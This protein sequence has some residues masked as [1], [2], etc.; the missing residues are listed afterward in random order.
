MFLKLKLLQN[1]KKNQ[2]KLSIYKKEKKNFFFKNLTG[3][4]TNLN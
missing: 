4:K 1:L 3:L 2:L